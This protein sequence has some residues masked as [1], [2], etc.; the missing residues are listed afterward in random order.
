[1]WLLEVNIK[2]MENSHNIQDFNMYNEEQKILIEQW[3]KMIDLADSNS[4]RRIKTNST[5][6][7]INSLITAGTTLLSSI[8]TSILSLFGMLISLLWFFSILNYRLTNKHRYFVIRELESHMQY[9][10][11]SDEYEKLNKNK[12]YLG[13]TIIEMLIPLVFMITFL[14]RFL[15]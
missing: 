12:F 8:P 14:T 3:K 4:E 15:C 6:I 10:P 2:Q 5:Y 1:M 7:T 9:H 13:N 11:I